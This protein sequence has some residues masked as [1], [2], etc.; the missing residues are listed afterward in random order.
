MISRIWHGYTTP[1]NANIYESLL[2][3]E[4][5][6]G[7]KDR[8]IPGFREIQVFRREL[9][10]EIEFVTVMWFDSIDAVRA[11]AGEDYEIAVVPEKARAVLSRFDARSQHYD[12]RE[13]V[14]AG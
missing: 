13:Q 2:K 1:E 11:F 7:I 5:I 4:V 9:G 8:E 3:G 12:V 14:K 6:I 10:D